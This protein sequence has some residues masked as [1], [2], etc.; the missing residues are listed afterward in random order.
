MMTTVR[1]TGASQQVSGKQER[2]RP[3]RQARWRS[4]SRRFSVG[5]V[6]WSVVGV[7]E[8]FQYGPGRIDRTLGW[9]C[10]FL[11]GRGPGGSGAAAFPV[12]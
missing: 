6:Q 4:E 7:G 8:G 11:G 1:D 9:S 5:G 2:A 12:R 10:Q 3:D